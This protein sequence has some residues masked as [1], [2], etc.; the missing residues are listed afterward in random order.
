MSVEVST[1]KLVDLRL[2]G[3]VEILEFVHRLELDDV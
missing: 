2:S 1:D 3:G